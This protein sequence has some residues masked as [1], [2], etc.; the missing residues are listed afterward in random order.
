MKREGSPT[1]KVLEFIKA[2]VAAGH[3]FPTTGEIERYMGWGS[4]R[5]ADALSR[6]AIW[7]ELDRRVVNGRTVF[8]L[9]QPKRRTA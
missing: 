5:G 8:S 2:R 1:R 3:P 9:K 4:S 6:L 7:G